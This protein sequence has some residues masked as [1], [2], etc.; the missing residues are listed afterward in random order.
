[1]KLLNYIPME[2]SFRPPSDQNYVQ[3]QKFQVFDMNRIGNRLSDNS[4]KLIAPSTKA[5]EAQQMFKQKNQQSDFIKQ[6]LQVDQRREVL[7]PPKKQQ[8][9]TKEINAINAPLGYQ[10]VIN[11]GSKS[12]TRI[13]PPPS[14]AMSTTSE[15][16]R[17]S[18]RSQVYDFRKFKGP[19]TAQA[20]KKALNPYQSHLIQQRIESRAYMKPL[21]PIK[22]NSQAQVIPPA[23][24]AISTIGDPDN[25]ILF[26]DNGMRLVNPINAK[27]P[28]PPLWGEI[29]E[30]ENYDPNEEFYDGEK[31]EAEMRRR[32][33]MEEKKRRHDGKK[34]K[35]KVVYVYESDESDKEDG[36]LIKRPEIRMKSEGRVMQS[37]G[38]RESSHEALR[39]IAHEYYSNIQPTQSRRTDT[40]SQQRQSHPSLGQQLPTIMKRFSVE[41]PQQQSYGS[42]KPV[43][44]MGGQ[45]SSSGM[46][47]RSI[48]SGAFQKLPMIVINSNNN[49]MK[50]Q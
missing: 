33:I 40:Y 10:A 45:I 39:N 37:S 14:Q 4:T 38:A 2:V 17:L 7:A 41:N 31:A 21:T 44:G 36:A 20:I 6:S 9:P 5:Y 13:Q 8:Q 47:S 16:G 48:R 35:R 12:Q 50:H 1:M 30:E 25:Q 18:Q 42:I 24:R 46:A 43:S 28:P 29:L 49:N 34:L 27:T 11:I 3:S 32:K 19:D 22:E 26:L 15:V 23:S